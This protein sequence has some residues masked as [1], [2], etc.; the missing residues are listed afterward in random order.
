MQLQNL[1]CRPAE[2]LQFIIDIEC[3]GFKKKYQEVCLNV[4]KI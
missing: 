1:Y 3:V 4:L 2:F